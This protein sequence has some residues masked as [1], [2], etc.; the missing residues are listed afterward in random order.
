MFFFV[1]YL[2]C[3]RNVEIALPPASSVIACLVLSEHAPHVESAFDVKTLWVPLP[4]P[5]GSFRGHLQKGSLARS[6]R[7]PLKGPLS[8]LRGPGGGRGLW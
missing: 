5:K 2:E 7:G 1:N 8:P 6:P 4:A 3:H